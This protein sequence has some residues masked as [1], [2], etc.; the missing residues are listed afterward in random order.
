MSICERVDRLAH[1][2]ALVAASRSGP[3]GATRV[4]ARRGD[5]LAHR[6]LRQQR[7][8][9]V[10]RDEHDA[11]ADRVV[12]VARLQRLAARRGS[13]R[14]RPARRRRA[15]RT[16]RPAPGRRARRCRAPRRRRAR[17]RRRRMPAKREAVDLER[18]DARPPASRTGA[19]GGVARA[20]AAAAARA[21][22]SPSMCATIVS[23]PP[24]CGHDRRDRAAVAQ[25]R[26]AVAGLDH[27]LEPVRDEQHRAARARAG[28]ASRRTRA[29]RGRT[30]ARP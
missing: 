27:L 3:S 4:V 23:S 11:G 8:Q 29:R 24:S 26:R 5:V 17:T 19:V 28:R 15:R 30:A 10:G 9:A 1:A 16:A 2:A 7:V 20:A 6:A 18:G 22:A 14:P 25:D 13:R 12:G 21:A